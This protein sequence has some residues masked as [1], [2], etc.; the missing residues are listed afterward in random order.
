MKKI[1]EK[2][3]VS[4]G[5]L[6]IINFIISNYENRIALF[7]TPK[8]NEKLKYTDEIIN[9]INSSQFNEIHSKFILTHMAKLS[10]LKLIEDFR[11]NLSKAINKLYDLVLNKI[12]FSNE[13]A[14]LE[15]LSKKLICLSNNHKT[16]LDYLDKFFD[17]LMNLGIVE[18]INLLDAQKYSSR[19]KFFNDLNEN[20]QNIDIIFNDFERNLR[21][22]LDEIHKKLPEIDTNSNIKNLVLVAG[23]GVGVGVGV[24]ITTGLVY[25]AGASAATIAVVA[26]ATTLAAVAVSSGAI[27]LGRV[28]AVKFSLGAISLGAIS[29]GPVAAI[30]IAAAIGSILLKSDDFFFNK[31][32]PW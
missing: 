10:C 9:C 31:L 28:A 27:S 16:N 3:G 7:V 14:F 25:L 1:K 11:Y 23:V 18:K 26:G 22:L 5:Q 2:E 6:K 8:N 13:K 15:N 19:F 20:D 30:P 12:K 24:C 4:E 29:L 17:L 32:E 21:T